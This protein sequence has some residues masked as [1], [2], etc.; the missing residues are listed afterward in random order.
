MFV[1]EVQ[2]MEGQAIC[3]TIPVGDFEV[4]VV[5]TGRDSNRRYDIKS[6]FDSSQI[7][8][9]IAV[10]TEEIIE[11]FNKAYGLSDDEFR[12]LYLS[13]IVALHTGQLAWARVDLQGLHVEFQFQ[14]YRVE[15]LH[16]R[17]HEPEW[18]LVTE[19]GIL[20]LVDSLSV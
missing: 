3:G 17:V 6:L 15:G 5:V 10:P 9:T 12:R 14:H 4:P 18:D 20:T 7:V 19:A 16:H 13:I 2:V 8:A 1:M 11:A